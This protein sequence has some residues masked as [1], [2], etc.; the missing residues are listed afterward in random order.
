[1]V[2][3][4]GLFALGITAPSIDNDDQVLAQSGN[5]ACVTAPLGVELWGI[6]Q[7][8]LVQWDVCPDEWS[9]DRRYR[10]EI[11]SVIRWR[12]STIADPSYWARTTNAGSGGEFRINGL[13]NGLKYAVQ[14]QLYRVEVKFDEQGRFVDERVVARGSW[15]N[16]Y[17]ATPGA[18]RDTSCDKKS[19][20]PAEP[21]NVRLWEHDRG[22]FVQWDVC[23]GYRYEIRWRLSSEEPKY[24]T[25]WRTTKNAGT[26]GEADIDYNVIA[27]DNLTDKQKEDLKKGETIEPKDDQKFPLLNDR[28]YVV[29]LRPI[30]VQGNFF[31]KGRWTDDYFAKPARCGDL[32]GVPTN[33]EVTSGDSVLTVTWDRCS[34][35]RSH[36]QWQA[37]GGAWSKPI[38][39]GNK[40]SYEIRNLDNGIKY[41]VQVRASAPSSGPFD[42]SKNGEPYATEWSRAVDGTPT[43]VCPT[44]KP[45]EPEEFVVVPG[46]SKLY[47]S[48]RPCRGYEYEL[49]YRKW[50]NTDWPKGEGWQSVA[51]NSSHTIRGLSNNTRYEVRVRIQND[52]DTITP[53]YAAKPQAPSKSNHSPGW[54]SV[55]ESISLVENRNYDTP[56]ATIEAADPDSGDAIR[57]EIVKPLPTPKPFP[58][59]INARD[60]EIYLYD[61]LDYE[62][63]EEYQLKVRAIDVYGAKIEHEIRVEVID[64]E[65]PPP[66]ILHTVC[67][68]GDDIAVAWSGDQSKFSFEIQHRLST[69]PSFP[70]RNLHKL[71]ATSRTYSS[72]TDGSTYVFRVRAIDKSTK[73]QSKWSSEE[74]VLVSKISNTAPEF[75]GDSYAFEVVEEQSA[76]VHVGF[77]TAIDSKILNPNKSD[78][79]EYEYEY[80]SVRYRIFESTPE[81]APFAV[82]PFTGIVTTTDRL[83]YEAQNTYSLVVGAT[84]LC[85]ASDYVDVTITVL[86]DPNIDATPL[87]PSAPSIIAKHD[88]VVV[89]WPTDHYAEYDLDWREV[90]EDY[91]SRPE[92]ADATMPRI[93]DLPDTD[94]SYAFRLRRVNQLGEPGEWSPE[95]IVDPSVKSPT[96]E[97][98]DVPRQGQVLGGVEMYVP[99]IAL[100]GGQT[101]RLGFNMFG[102]DGSLDNSLIDRRDVTALWRI[103]D[104]DLSDDR[105][106]VAS[107]TAPDD[108]GVYKI[109]IVVKQTVPGGIVQ[110]NL[111][112]AV[113]V[114]GSNNLI[115]PFRSGGEVPRNFE[116]DGVTYGAISYFEAKE[117]RPPAASKAL[118]K[119]REG[120]IPS[121]EW[122]GVLIEPGDAASTLQSRLDGYTAVGDIFTSQF[123][124]KDGAPIINMSF[125]SSAAMCLPVPVEWTDSLQSLVVMRIT[126]SGELAMMDLP[127]RFQP[128]PTFNDPALVCGHSEVFDGQ[129]FLGIA[130]EDIVTPT[131]T[132]TPTPIPTDTPTVTPTVEPTAVPTDTATP[133]PT[134]DPLSVVVI[135]TSTPTPTPTPEPLPATPTF[136]ATPAPTATHT[137]TPTLTPTSTPTPEPTATAVP[138][139][140]PTATPMPTDT[141]VPVVKSE[142]TATAMPTA[143]Q[144]AVPTSTAVPTETPTSIPEPTHT[145]VPTVALPAPSPTV[146]AESP[147]DDREDAGT[148]LGSSDSDDSVSVSL[149]VIAVI[150]FVILGVAIASYIVYNNRVSRQLAGAPKPEEPPAEAVNGEVAPEDEDDP[151]ND[152]DSDSD[153]RY[154]TLRFGS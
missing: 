151:E 58:F 18:N 6:D 143:T 7:G 32:P 54:K 63:I 105:G 50:S 94:S 27:F 116:V 154:D 150:A 103:S 28:K 133:T 81:D 99:G 142:A 59:A 87:V 106:R 86:D 132:S 102:I 120:S 55:P 89:I 5:S 152:D 110:R 124:S 22:I 68:T 140:I 8:V 139:E 153:S 64:A 145:P 93:V 127:V 3:I 104:G 82:H 141:P 14:L 98:I 83:D 10:Y 15:T 148:P 61:K 136:T 19:G 90:G 72:L 96:I 85:G 114:V 52:D 60:G 100:K 70:Q 48:W 33:V 41:K 37:D 34:G 128:N 23:P 1:M 80:S 123:V 26:L 138:P 71:D 20:A 57:Y 144:T 11:R 119:V 134:P 97:P 38:D 42:K 91:R 31:D 44:G 39:V 108:E 92:D 74:S 121:Y 122:I 2:I 112:M 21:N 56:I 4:A 40:T 25:A 84:D 146:D 117:Y 130:N 47:V 125:I 16:S 131:P 24:P 95:T 79:D 76:G 51:T 107:Y 53:E 67:P 69:A 77:T 115:K 66:P 135:G 137:P 62:L 17:F 109:S 9:S 43:S 111:D 30:H 46:D 75:R 147:S 65:G 78:E 129:M 101:A 88:Q 13:V 149:I 36:I 113:H 29:Q 35:A 118:F 45:V 126:P 73:E 49:A 12:A